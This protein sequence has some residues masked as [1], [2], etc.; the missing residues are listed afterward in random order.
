M[1]WCWALRYNSFIKLWLLPAIRCIEKSFSKAWTNVMAKA[2][3]AWDYNLEKECQ[4]STKSRLALG[5]ISHPVKTTWVCLKTC[6]NIKCDSVWRVKPYPIPNPFRAAWIITLYNRC[7]AS[8]SC[9]KSEFTSCNL[10]GGKC[11]Y[12]AI[13]INKECLNEM[14]SNEPFA[15][16]RFGSLVAIWRDEAW[17]SRVFCQQQPCMYG[18]HLPCRAPRFKKKAQK[19]TLL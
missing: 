18:I 9:H 6:S 2:G 11:W 16:W 7:C 15:I 3:A 14:K 4:L 10:N 13:R 19:K 1:N 8:L 17:V 12:E 5:I